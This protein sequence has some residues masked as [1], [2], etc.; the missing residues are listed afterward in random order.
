MPMELINVWCEGGERIEIMGEEGR[1]TVGESRS[2]RME[3]VGE[4]G[5]DTIREIVEEV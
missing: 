4:N 3:S 1:R 5:N 2:W